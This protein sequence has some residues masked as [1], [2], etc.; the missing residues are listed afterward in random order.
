[1]DQPPFFKKAY[2]FPEEGLPVSF[3]NIYTD[4]S[5]YFVT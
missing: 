1:M 5:A 3:R 4:Q 2:N